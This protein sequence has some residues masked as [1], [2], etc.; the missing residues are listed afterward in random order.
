MRTFEFPSLRTT[1]E[2]N[3]P[4]VLTEEEYLALIDEHCKAI[5]VW[6]KTIFYHGTTQDVRNGL[7]AVCFTSIILAPKREHGNELTKKTTT[8]LLDVYGHAFCELL[9]CFPTLP[10]VDREVVTKRR[11]NPPSEIWI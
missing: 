2:N 8:Q 7:I 3:Q 1:D 5:P 4:L 10:E 11:A 6:V 9:G